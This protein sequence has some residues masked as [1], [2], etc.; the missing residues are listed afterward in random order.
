MN[1]RIFCGFLLLIALSLGSCGSSDKPKEG[2]EAA[3]QYQ[4]PMKC[5]NE[6]FSKPGK[7]P[8]CQMDLET[9]SNS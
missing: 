2:N 8:V 9:V 7:C 3:V 5:T 6:I 1:N 4:C